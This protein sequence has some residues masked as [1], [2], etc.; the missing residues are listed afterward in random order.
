MSRMLVFPP[1]ALREIESA[2]V[3]ATHMA[4][5]TAG[6][7]LQLS[8]IDGRTLAT[9]AR[10]ALEIATGEVVWPSDQTLKLKAPRRASGIFD[11]EG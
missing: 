2:I 3:T 1:A 11:I 8:T 9:A 10:V 7:K 5:D 4:T 6:E